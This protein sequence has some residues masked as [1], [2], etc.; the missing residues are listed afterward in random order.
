MSANKFAALAPTAPVPDLRLRLS[1]IAALVHGELVGDVDPWITG[2]AGIHDAEAGDLTFLAQRRYRSA[3]KHSRAVAVLVDAHESVDRPAIRVADP[4]L[5]FSQVLRRFSAASAR[6][7]PRPSSGPTSGSSAR[8]R[9][10]SFVAGSPR[11]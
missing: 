4:A 8:F 11:R 1:E 9:S 6:S 7:I 3:L 10:G 5:A 2:L